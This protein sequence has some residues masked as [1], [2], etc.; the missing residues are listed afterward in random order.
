MKDEE[1]NLQ[2]LINA[3]GWSKTRPRRLIIEGWSTNVGRGKNNMKNYLI[4]I[5][6]FALSCNSLNKPQSSDKRIYY[7]NLN[8]YPKEIN[9]SNLKIFFDETR[10]AMY[11]IHCQDTCNFLK[12]DISKEDALFGYLDLRFEKTTHF[13]DT[14]ELSFCFYKDSLRCDVTTISTLGGLTYG[15]AF[16]GTRDSIIYYLLNSTIRRFMGFGIKNRYANPLQPEVIAF[17]KS[18]QDKLNPWFKAEAKRRKVIE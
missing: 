1:N 6:G 12:K 3:V 8:Y 7:K 15:A 11:C 4:F 18:N 13:S 9:N 5:C 2:R 10:W 16:K 17:I 14:T